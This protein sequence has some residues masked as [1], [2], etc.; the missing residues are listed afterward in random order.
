M[1]LRALVLV[2]PADVPVRAV[3]ALDVS[4]PTLAKLGARRA[5]AR[6]DG[7][8][9]DGFAEVE[10]VRQLEG[11]L[12][13]ARVRELADDVSA[14]VAIDGRWHHEGYGGAP[15]ALDGGATLDLGSWDPRV[16]LH[17]TPP[18]K[19]WRQ[20]VGQLLAAAQRTPGGAWL[21][22]ASFAPVPELDRA[23]EDAFGIDWRPDELG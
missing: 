17:R 12:S 3:H 18:S 22:E 8:T 9:V 6:Y 19:T 4:E 23:Y 13:E 7:R 10:T 14:V 5:L 2:C 11:E 1:H 21:C 16:L 20:R 15:L